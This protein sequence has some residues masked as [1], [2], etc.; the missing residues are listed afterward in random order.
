[1]KKFL[2]TTFILLFTVAHSALGYY[3]IKVRRT[4]LKEK[5]LA[6][7]RVITELKFS[8]KVRIIKQKGPYYYISTR[9][10]KGYVFRTAIDDHKSFKKHY[11]QIDTSRG[12]SSDSLTAAT[13]GFSKAETSYN[14]NTELRYDLV[15]KAL[16]F[17]KNHKIVNNWKKFRQ[18][19]KIG[20]YKVLIN[21]KYY[22]YFSR[23]K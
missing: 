13:K 10:G 20:E 21:S 14:K 1:M 3:V 23:R 4:S 8:T 19:G 17:S 15:N 22:K 2:F 18:K 12:Y 9:K 5:P 16:N 7:S 11:A 6:F